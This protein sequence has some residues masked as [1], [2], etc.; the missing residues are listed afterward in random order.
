MKIEIDNHTIEFRINSTGSMDPWSL[1]YAHN[2]KLTFMI[3]ADMA[4]FILVDGDDIYKVRD[5]GTIQED[6]FAKQ[7]ITTWEEAKTLLNDKCKYIGSLKKRIDELTKSKVNQVE[8]NLIKIIK[9]EI[10]LNRTNCGK[11]TKKVF[12]YTS[13]EYNKGYRQ[14]SDDLEEWL[15]EYRKEIINKVKNNKEE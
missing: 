12:E 3:T 13:P 14:C 8:Y 5:W 10:S 7:S 2:L 1:D 4:E 6:M 11:H 9:N 15:D